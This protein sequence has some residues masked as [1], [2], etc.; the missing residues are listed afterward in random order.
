MTELRRTDYDT[1]AATARF[2]ELGYP[3][4]EQMLGPKDA[5][6]IA[7][8]FEDAAGEPVSPDSLTA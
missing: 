4:A 5:D 8:R 3:M 2:R 6:A 7:R 1:E